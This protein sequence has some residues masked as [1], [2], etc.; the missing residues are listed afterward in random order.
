MTKMKERFNEF[1]Q[2]LLLLMQ[3]GNLIPLEECMATRNLNSE[4]KMISYKNGYELK[5]TDLINEMSVSNI[6]KD[7]SEIYS[8]KYIENKINDFLFEIYFDDVTCNID[9]INYFFDELKDNLTKTENYLVPIFIDNVLFHHTE[10][11]IGK[12]TFIPYSIFNLRRTFQDAGYTGN[13]VP[14]SQ[15]IDMP[16][17]KSVGIVSVCA[18]DVD[19][20]IEKAEELVDQSLNVIRLFNFHSEFGIQGKYNHPLQYEIHVLY[21]DQNKI[22]SNI[23]WSGDII[24]CKIEGDLYKG[25]GEYVSSVDTILK[26]SGRDRNKMENKLLLAINL[27]GAIQK[28]KDQKENIIRIFTALETLLI[29]GNEIKIDNI[30]DR[31][32]FINKSDK[33]ARLDVYRFVKKMYGYRNKLVHEG[34]A[35]FNELDYYNLLKELIS[36]IL[37]IAINIDKYPDVD[38]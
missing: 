29:S 24:G 16:M 17:V 15:R 2:A 19:N 8:R 12:V 27:V 31:I 14:K 20:A 13:M 35:V 10:I 1:C 34:E 37:I 18:G 6:F 33:S 36:C 25:Y 5:L 7:V 4:E 9:R 32:A 23:G 3:E 28:N 11:T 38:D 30:A 22:H 26:K 21:L